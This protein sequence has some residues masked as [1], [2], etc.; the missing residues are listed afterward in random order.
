MLFEFL[1]VRLW[2][3]PGKVVYWE[4][5][6][7]L[8]LADL[9]LGKTRH[10]RKAGIPMPL[11]SAETDLKALEAAL[12]WYPLE[13]VYFLGDLFHSD[14]NL[15]WGHFAD[16]LG[17]WPGIRFVLVVGNHDIF[18]ETVYKEAGLD[19]VPEGLCLGPFFLSH[20]PVEPDAVPESFYNLAGHLHPGVV[21][22]GGGRQFLKLPCFYFG[23]AGGVLPAF[24][25]LTGTMALQP[26]EDDQVFV[27]CEGEVLSVPVVKR[28]RGRRRFF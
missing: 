19:L 13:T 10:F 18:P 24:G 25:A 27:V 9:H 7:A 17:R 3:H 4:E 26:E 23:S 22:Q 11:E 15:D 6:K 28:G 1:G 20:I 14:R 5:E 2:L 12:G 16:L 21:L 8:L